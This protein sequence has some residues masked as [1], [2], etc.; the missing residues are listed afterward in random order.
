MLENPDVMANRG[1]E[2]IAEL[3]YIQDKQKAAAAA[4]APQEKPEPRIRGVKE[5]PTRQALRRESTES[6]LNTPLELDRRGAVEVSSELTQAAETARGHTQAYMVN[7]FGHELT[8]KVNNFVGSYASGDDSFSSRLSNMVTQEKEGTL[9]PEDGQVLEAARKVARDAFGDKPRKLYRG[10]MDV[11]DML[12]GELPEK[13]ED[14]RFPSFKVS[15]WTTDPMVANEF[16]RGTGG[17]GA[18]DSSGGTTV[19]REV[20]PDEVLFAPFLHDDPDAIEFDYQKEFTLSNLSGH[21]D[22]RVEEVHP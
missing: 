11:P 17:G 6:Y 10:V 9:S 4:A 7:T 3:A 21:F 15:S 20:H 13:G 5:P 1:E 16:A 19:S 14:I 2:V 8:A 18:W 12:G 22:V